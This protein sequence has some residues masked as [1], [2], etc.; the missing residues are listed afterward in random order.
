MDARELTTDDGAQERQ[1]TKAVGAQVP[2]EAKHQIEVAATERSSPDETVRQTD[3][4]R[5]ALSEYLDI[6]LDELE[7]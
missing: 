6:P 2:K 5:R 3:L 7:P 1:E 4:V